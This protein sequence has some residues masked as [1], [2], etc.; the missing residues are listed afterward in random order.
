MDCVYDGVSPNWKICYSAGC[1]TGG[2][3][4]VQNPPAVRLSQPATVTY[5]SNGTCTASSLPALST[6]GGD[7][8][9]ATLAATLNT[10]RVG[11]FISA[12]ECHLHNAHV[13]SGC[14]ARRPW[15]RSPL[16]FLTASRSL[17][18]ASRCMLRHPLTRPFL[19][20]PHSRK[21]PHRQRALRRR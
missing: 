11:G 3:T 13:D 1:F 6:L 17:P 19:C 18:A 10:Y 20:F 8:F 4:A 21:G 14:A 16:E 12:A 9:L 5:T 2:G 15:A 7:A